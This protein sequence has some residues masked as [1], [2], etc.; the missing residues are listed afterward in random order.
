MVTKYV[1][2]NHTN[3]LTW[4]FFPRIMITWEEI[5]QST[6]QINTSPRSLSC[7]TN[8]PAPLQPSLPRL[9]SYSDPA[10]P[11]PKTADRAQAEDRAAAMVAAPPPPAAHPH[12]VVTTAAEAEDVAAT[13]APAATPPA[14]IRAPMTAQATHA[15]GGAP[16]TP[17][18][19]PAEAAAQTMR[20][21]TPAGV[22]APTTVRTT[23]EDGRWRLQP[24]ASIEPSGSGRREI[25]TWSMRRPSSTSTS[26]R[27][28]AHSTLSAWASKS[29]ATVCMR[30][31]TVL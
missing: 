4:D 24:S 16:M 31:A 17:P 9:L 23:A 14:A 21:A 7:E 27:Q 20:P 30:P 1:G 29:P 13:M 10:Q 12:P 28:P 5:P 3:R 8:T 18:A 26:K 25:S 22:V 11:S 15:A 2:K 19:M 6:V